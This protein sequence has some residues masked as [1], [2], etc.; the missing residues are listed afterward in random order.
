MIFLLYTGTSALIINIFRCASISWFQVV[1]ESVIDVFRLAHLRVFQSYYF[2][3]Q[4]CTKRIVEV[5]CIII[6]LS[7]IQRQSENTCISWKW[8]GLEWLKEPLDSIGL[9]RSFCRW[10]CCTAFI[11][12]GGRIKYF[13]S[14]LKGLQRRVPPLPHTTI[15]SLCVRF[16]IPRQFCV[17]LVNSMYL[18][19]F[20]PPFIELSELLG[21]C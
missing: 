4:L 5:K 3:V 20:H 18:L 17:K 8:V 9:V 11:G 7:N 14:S 13:F 12:K 16:M 2:I 10:K 6:N 1:S 19:E 15:F 21:N